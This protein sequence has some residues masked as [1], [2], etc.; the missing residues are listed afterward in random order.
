M[1]DMDYLF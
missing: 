1:I